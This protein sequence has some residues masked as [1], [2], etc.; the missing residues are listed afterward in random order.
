MNTWINAISNICKSSFGY[1]NCL[2]KRDWPY[3]IKCMYSSH[4][5]WN[6]NFW[7]SNLVFSFILVFLTVDFQEGK[8]LE[9]NMETSARGRMEASP[10]AWSLGVRIRVGSTWDFPDPSALRAFPCLAPLPRPVCISPSPQHILCLK[11][12]CFQFSSL[13]SRLQQS[14]RQ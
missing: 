13:D 11:V 3:F 9:S 7:E 5:D 14:L 10:S 2:S 1:I 12:L 8:V 4:I 6:Q